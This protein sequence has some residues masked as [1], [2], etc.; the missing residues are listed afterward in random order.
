MPETSRHAKREY[1]NCLEVG[2]NAYEVILR[3]GLLADVHDDPS[4]YADLITTPA[5]AK[6][7]LRT[8]AQSLSEYEAR[9]GEIVELSCKQQT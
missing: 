2:F 8:L 7:F 4:I 9:F 5:H 6:A 3:F 1:V